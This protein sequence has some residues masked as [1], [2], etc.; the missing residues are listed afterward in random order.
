MFL[1]MAKL[2]FLLS[3]GPRCIHIKPNWSILIEYLWPL[4]SFKFYLIANYIAKMSL[5]VNTKFVL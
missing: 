4:G 5:E 3:F 2:A 1:F